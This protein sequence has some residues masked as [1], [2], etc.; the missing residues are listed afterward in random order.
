MHGSIPKIQSLL[1]STF[2]VQFSNFVMQNELTNP[3]FI[4]TSLSFALRFPLFRVWH[5]GGK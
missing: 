1:M 4:E 2:G 5:S 3:L